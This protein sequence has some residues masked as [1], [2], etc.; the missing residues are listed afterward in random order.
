MGKIVEN[1]IK[2]ENREQNTY[3]LVPFQAHFS[4]FKAR[5][6]GFYFKKV[7]FI[8]RGKRHYYPN[9]NDYV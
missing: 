5:I 9:K 4:Q 1:Y 7:S 8:Q 6:K 3:F 2:D